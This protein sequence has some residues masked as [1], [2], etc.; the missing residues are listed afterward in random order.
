MDVIHVLLK[1]GIV[2]YLVFPE[3]PLPNGTLPVP[4]LRGIQPIVAVKNR[5][6]SLRKTCL[7]QTP[8]LGKIVIGRRQGPD[9][10]KVVRQ[11]YQALMSKG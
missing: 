6:G 1:I 10:M 8:P 9:A 5:F 11:Q 3:P 7:D 4:Y 2:A